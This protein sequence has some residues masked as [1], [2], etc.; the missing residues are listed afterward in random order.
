[1][2]LIDFLRRKSH[3][4]VPP[5]D[6]PHISLLRDIRDDPSRVGIHEGVKVFREVYLGLARKGQVDL[7]A[8][9]NNGKL[10]LVEGTVVRTNFKKRIKDARRDLNRQLRIAFD[11]F[12][13]GF[14]IEPILIRAYRTPASGDYIHFHRLPMAS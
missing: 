9:T 7:A 8:L 13:E 1:M 4:Y 3:D 10:Y 11:Y 5:Q 2:A 14:G 12:R 6:E